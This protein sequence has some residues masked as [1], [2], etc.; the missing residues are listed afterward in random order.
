MN[1]QE[2]D[3]AIRKKLE[4]VGQTFTEADIEKVFQHVTTAKPTFWQWLRGHWYLPAITLVSISAVVVFLFVNKSD[5][6]D[7]N[8]APVKEVASTTSLVTPEI[9]DTV[10]PSHDTEKVISAG[11][12]NLPAEKVI[13]DASANELK[14]QIKSAEPSLLSVQAA[15]DAPRIK[16]REA[17]SESKTNYPETPV[18]AAAMDDGP[19]VSTFSKEMIKEEPQI[20]VPEKIADT[21]TGYQLVNNEPVND[22]P[23]TG[24]EPEK[25]NPAEAVKPVENVG[26]PESK[27]DADRD[28]KNKLNLGVPEFKGLT[29][30]GA[31]NLS[32]LGFGPALNAELLFGKGFGF[33]TG[34]RYFT[35]YKEQFKS[36]E[37]MERDKHHHVHPG[38]NEHFHNNDQFSDITIRNQILQVPLKLTYNLPLRKQFS[39]QLSLGTEWDVYVNQKLDI[40]QRIDSSGKHPGHFRESGNAVPFNNIVFS[41]GIEKQWKKFSFQVSPFI[42]PSLRNVFYKPKDIEFGVSVGFGYVFGK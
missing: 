9:Q 40:E 10:Q 24:L 36:R 12:H 29:L 16:T 5:S 41:A 21:S 42:S 25:T 34:I 15:K 6:P 30:S 38:I 23:E 2:F 35:T 7:F 14:A 27:G 4:G 19:V 26:N 33:T 31:Y 39:L 8:D 1:N 37:E 32:N 3:D 20:S 11:N 22:V 18:S 13:S 17:K 28:K